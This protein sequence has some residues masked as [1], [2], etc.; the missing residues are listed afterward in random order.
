MTG[1][2]RVLTRG[3][4]FT[5]AVSKIFSC[6]KQP[7]CLCERGLLRLLININVP[8]MTS[9]GADITGIHN[10]LSTFGSDSLLRVK[11]T[12][13]GENLILKSPHYREKKWLDCLFL[14]RCGTCSKCFRWSSDL[15]KVSV[16]HVIICLLCPVVAVT[17]REHKKRNRWYASHRETARRWRKFYLVDKT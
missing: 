9:R 12:F 2:R 3:G 16:F 7:F 8:W 4:Q 10:S 1:I 17:S 15:E 13:K 5:A 11:H 6:T 14:L